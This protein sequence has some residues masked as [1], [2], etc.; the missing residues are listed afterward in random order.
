[1]PALAAVLLVVLAAAS[2]SRAEPLDGYLDL[3]GPG[4]GYMEVADEPALN[5]TSAIT[6]EAWVYLYSYSGFGATQTEC[7]MLVAKNWVEAFALGLACGSDIGDAFINGTELPGEALIP[8]ET[9][10]HLAMTFDGFWIRSYVNGELDTEVLLDLQPIGSTTDPL[11][12]GHDVEW[13]FSPHA[14]IDDVRIWNIARSEAHIASTMAG[15]RS[16]AEGLIANWTFDG[17]SLL[18]RVSA[19]PG[20]LQGDASIQIGDTP[21]PT[22][23]PSPSPTPTAAPTPSGNP[24]PPQAKGDVNCDGLLGP[25]DVAALLGALAG[26]TDVPSECDAAPASLAPAR[27]DIDC[28]GFVDPRDALALISNIAG[29]DLLLPDCPPIGGTPTPL[30][31]PSPSPV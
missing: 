18:D 17:G 2:S 20:I 3:Q 1:V 21:T 19:R 16:D 26:V 15:V 10:T 23:S 14:R 13:D 29:I 25:A 28:S 22:P 5:P 7:P 6:I 30:A 11:R 4:A 9:W 8:L 12:I 24:V 31:T 27:L